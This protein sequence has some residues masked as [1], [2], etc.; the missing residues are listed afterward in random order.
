MEV[1]H[2]R[3]TR[4]LA[5]DYAFGVSILGLIPIAGLLTLKLLIA[6]ALI[7]RML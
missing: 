1:R 5:L 6:I 4:N 2:E 3:E 7:V